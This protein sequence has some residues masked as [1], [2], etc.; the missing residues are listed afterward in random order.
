MWPGT[1]PS[2]ATF[3][4]RFLR[5]QTFGGFYGTPF[6]TMS[7][8]EVEARMKI[9]DR[10]FTEGEKFSH[11]CQIKDG[12]C[13]S[14]TGPTC[15]MRDRI[16]QRCD[17]LGPDGCRITTLKCKLWFCGQVRQ[18]HPEIDSAMQVA[19]QEL[20]ASLPGILFYES[21]EGYK[22]HLEKMVLN[23]NS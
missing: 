5:K 13:F 23:T 12:E 21:R 16:S 8:Q 18:A 10:L 15:C 22:A 20:E 9:Y 2:T 3:T 11:L 1:G 4:T 19:N 17:H 14:P 7:P 6:I